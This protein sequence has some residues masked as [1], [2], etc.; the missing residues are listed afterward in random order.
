MHSSLTRTSTLEA[1][2]PSRWLPWP[3]RVDL[4]LLCFFGL[5][6]ATCDRVNMAVAAPFIIR[7]YGW[8]LAR[9]GWVLSLFYIGYVAC[10]IPAGFLADHAS[11]IANIKQREY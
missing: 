11:N 1:R 9:M 7:D 6:L 8:S 3:K 4:S 5:L 10:R 2:L